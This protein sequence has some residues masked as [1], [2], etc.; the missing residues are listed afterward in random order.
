MKYYNLYYKGSK[1]NNR[2]L[3]EEET[4]NVKQSLEIHK[5]NDVTNKLESIP[6]YKIKFIK[7][8]MI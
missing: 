2:P 5:K 6:V 3:N 7:T 1:L 8:I 4:N